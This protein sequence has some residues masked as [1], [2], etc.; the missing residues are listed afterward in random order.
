MI[1]K[2]LANQQPEWGN[3]SQIDAV[4][5]YDK[6]R[7]GLS[8]VKIIQEPDPDFEFEY[9]VLVIECP[10]CFNNH[11]IYLNNSMWYEN[12]FELDSNYCVMCETEFIVNPQSEFEILVKPN[13]DA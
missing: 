11:T 3:R 5:L 4:R 12:D 6:I 9:D 10:C 2:L 1:G 7:N 13:Q 8:P